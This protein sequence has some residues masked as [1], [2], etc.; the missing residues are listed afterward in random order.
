MVDAVAMRGGWPARHLGRGRRQGALDP[1]FIAIAAIKR[2]APDF[3]AGSPIM[4]Q[5]SPQVGAQLRA[6]LSNRSHDGK[7]FADP[8]MIARQLCLRGGLYKIGSRRLE[9]AHPGGAD[10]L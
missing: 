1:Q 3:D 7:R 5:L 2:C 8:A 10:S 6:A 4:M 9:D